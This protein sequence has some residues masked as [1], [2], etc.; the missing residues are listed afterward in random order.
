MLAL[1][2][3]TKYFLCYPFGKTFVVR[4]D[5]SAL[6]YLR[7]FADHNTR[8]MRWSLKLSELDFI[9]EHRPGSKIGHVDA[10]SRHVGAVV[11]EG[12][13]NKEAIRREQE[14]DNFCVKQNPGALS[15]KREFF[16][17]NEGIIYRRR[18]HDK[19]QVLIPRTLIQRVIEENHTPKFVAHPGIKRTY[20]LIS[21][22]FWWP[23]MR[24]SIEEYIQRCDPCQ[25][26]KE[27]REFRA[28]LG[29]VD[30]PTTPFEVT[31]MDITG[32]YPMTPRKNKYLLTFI[33]C[34]SKYTEAW[35]IPDM[36]AETC[37]RV[38]ATQI[39]SRHGTGSKLI[40]DQGPAF[41]SSFFKET[42]KILGVRKVHTTSYHPQSNSVERF[43]R[44]L[45]VGLSH[46]V[47]ATNTNW[48][49][50][51]SFY[52]MAYRATPNTVTGYS[53]FYLLHGKEMLLPTSEDLR[54]KIS[55]SPPD[56][57]QRLKNLKKSLRTAYKAVRQANMRSH[58]QNK[59]L[60]DRKAKLRSFEIGSFVY[61]YT[62]A[63]KPGLSRKFHRP[64]SG[65]HRF[66]AKV[67]DLNY[68]IQD[69]SNKKQVVHVNRLKQAYNADNWQPKTSPK[70]KK[71][72]NRKL[73]TYAS[74]EE[75][76]EV[77]IGT[78]PLLQ[79]AHQE[80]E[81]EPRTPPDRVPN[82]PLPQTVETPAS[83]RSNP[84]YAPCET[85]RSRRE[86]QSTRTEP[87]LTRSRTRVMS[88][89]QVA[90]VN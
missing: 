24:R 42:C 35:P 53:P 56:H 10:L 64:W 40:T 29:Q 71:K 45:H 58:Q 4:T 43:H 21:L 23:G 12:N 55:C 65:P 25:R 27:N 87:P 54:A 69:R 1:V 20:D 2:W 11:L 37:A 9:V 17:D 85:P 76:D 52:L 3:A 39:I 90:N 33:D 46:Y 28:P 50:L 57:H 72:H 88:E 75:E 19:H 32:P 31:S 49:E 81:N 73:P 86:L 7:N 30:E 62:P 78:F 41:M 44:S 8:L 61:L 5:H 63:V 16:R 89:D 66:T 83:E 70:A 77:R 60:Y 67:S 36:R 74:E 6:S 59:R 26:R 84:T 68:E 47:N 22:K 38:Y 80:K 48:D 13:L 51:V 15:R 79:T 14:K 18:P 82:T 34:F